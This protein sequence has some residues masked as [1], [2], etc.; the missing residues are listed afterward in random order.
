MLS[1]RLCPRLGTDLFAPFVGS[2]T[3]CFSRSPRFDAA[4]LVAFLAL[5]FAAPSLADAAT[6]TGDLGAA[7][8]ASALLAV[9][10][11]SDAASLTVQVT[12]LPPVSGAFV[13]AQIKKGNA[14]TNTT[15]PID[16]DGNPSPLVFVNGGTG[17]Y[18]VFVDKT[19]AGTETYT[20][21]AQCWTGA[22]G[23]GA[24]TGTT[25]FSTQGSPVATGSFAARLMLAATLVAAGTSLLGLRARAPRS[26]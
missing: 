8:S 4:P 14:A 20:V 5:A 24:A 15:D 7:A 11:A 23:T 19:D 17:R 12:N 3:S 16:G 2:E 22:G 1:S 13:G 6:L 21:A 10:C 25:L 9:D 26:S 18:D